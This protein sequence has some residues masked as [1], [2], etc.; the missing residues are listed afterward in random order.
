VVE[1]QRLQS[2]KLVET[3]KP[4]SSI[5]WIVLVLAT[6]NVD[7]TTDFVQLGVINEIM[8]ENAGMCEIDAAVFNEEQEVLWFKD[9]GGIFQVAACETEV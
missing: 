1:L 5:L 3:V 2:V 7:G 8:V 4:M 6:P 9:G